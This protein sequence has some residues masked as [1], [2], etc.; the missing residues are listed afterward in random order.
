MALL[1]VTFVRFLLMVGID[2]NS[3]NQGE[4]KKNT[5]YSNDDFP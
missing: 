5:S 4:K 3:W 2:E 1:N